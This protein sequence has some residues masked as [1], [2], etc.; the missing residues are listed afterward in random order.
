MISKKLQLCDACHFSTDKLKLVAV[1]FAVVCI[2]QIETRA[3]EFTR[4][5]S[6]LNPIVT[7]STTGH[8]TGASWVD[9]DNDND[10]DLFVASSGGSQLYRNDGGGAFTRITTGVLVT[11]A[12]NTPRGITWGDYD[13]DGDIDCFIAGV[14]SGLFQNDGVGNFTKIATGDIATTDTRGWSCGWA[15]Y[16]RDGYLDLAISFPS[17]F[18]TLPN[19]PNHLFHNDGPPSYSF[20]RVDTGVIVTGLEPYTNGTWSDYDDDGDIDFFM[21]SGPANS[22]GGVDFLYKNEQSETGN[23][24]FSRITTT[25]IATDILDGQTWNWIDYDNDGDLDGFVTNWGG[26]APALRTNK[27]YRND[28][29][30]YT[31]ITTGPLVNDIS[32]SLSNVWG[33]IDNDGD[34][35]VV[36]ITDGGYP[37]RQY[38]NNGDGTFSAVVS[39]DVPATTALNSGGSLGD[40][41]SDGDLDLFVCGPTTSRR[42]FNNTADQAF[43]YKWLNCHLV[44]V[45]SN[46]SVIGAVV[47]IKATIDGTPVWQRRDVSASN[48]FM[49]H[50]DLDPHFGL[51]NAITV[52]SALVFWPSGAK[53]VL[54]NV[55]SN[56][57]LTILECSG[58][59]ADGDGVADNC[60]NCVSVMNTDQVD[61]DF[62]GIGDECDDC[63]DPDHD[64][65]GSVG[66]PATNC[67]AD[68]CPMIANPGQEDGDADGIGNVCDNCPTIAN[69]NQ[70][71]VDTDLVGDLCDNCPA[72]ANGLQEDTDGDNVGDVCDECPSQPNPCTCCDLAGDADNGGDVSISDAVFLIAYIFQAG[73]APPCSA[74]GDADGGGDVNIGD[75]THLIVYI[76]QSGPTPICGT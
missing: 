37:L 10:V 42:L 69:M 46:R 1:S 41:D 74:E 64:G 11:T 30:V 6:A 60:D 72:V 3:Q 75:A 20:T 70:S 39:G 56:Q 34:I 36:V 38:D 26:A 14:T 73:A 15:D 44:G 31:T 17:G 66:F 33:D 12:L 2:L 18:V 76:F 24:G 13:N 63:V 8:Y 40:Y 68:N 71:D 4:V 55:S 9:Y 7:G 49:G 61:G 5:S 28:G 67:P 43:G 54:T 25:P 35:D 29:G 47:K 32:V 19:V 57:T 22:I 59:D 23:A 52:D 21:G 62:D 45:K 16:D 48:S 58:S 50:N 51:K 27:L 65:Y 53:T